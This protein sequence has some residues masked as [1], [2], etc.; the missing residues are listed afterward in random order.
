MATNHSL[1]DLQLELMQVLWAKGEATVQDVVKS[2]DR[3]LAQSTVATLLSRLEKRG[4]VTHT[5]SGRQ[6]VYRAAVGEAEVRRA[7]V[8]DLTDLADDLFNGDVAAL[9]SQLLSAREVNPE[10]LAR[11]RSLVE[12]KERE[13]EGT[14]P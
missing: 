9:V 10:D 6:Y 3:A 5:V 8:Q 14:D 2:L 13:L 11:V 7:M 4:L 12:A 1:T